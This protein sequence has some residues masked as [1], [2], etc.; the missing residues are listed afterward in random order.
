MQPVFYL[1]AV[2]IITLIGAGSVVC[3]EIFR[4]EGYNAQAAYAIIGIC[5]P[6]ITVLLGIL[7]SVGNGQEIKHLHECAHETKEKAKEAVQIAVETK[8]DIIKAINGGI[9]HHAVTKTND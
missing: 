9:K 3:L 5:T 7:K 8:N 6:T 2:G 4:P 1:L